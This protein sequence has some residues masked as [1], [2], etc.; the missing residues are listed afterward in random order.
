MSNRALRR[1]RPLK[2]LKSF[3]SKGSLL[4]SQVDF[5][6]AS[7]PS[8]R[9]LMNHIE[10]QFGASHNW[11]NLGVSWSLVCEEPE[12]TEKYL[13]SSESSK[14][15]WKLDQFCIDELSHP[16]RVYH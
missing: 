13:L 2:S 7:G 1:S 11:D 4:A 10:N 6:S 3:K 5:T 16:K 12:D 14:S 15:R 9:D 8:L